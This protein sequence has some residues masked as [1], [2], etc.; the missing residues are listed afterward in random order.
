MEEASGSLNL[1]S[2]ANRCE[3]PPLSRRRLEHLAI[4]DNLDVEEEEDSC[5]LLKNAGPADTISRPMSP[6]L[7]LRFEGGPSGVPPWKESAE[8]RGGLRPHFAAA[9]HP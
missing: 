8:S 6:G 4:F 9:I 7:S 2:M 5:G 1:V 3:S